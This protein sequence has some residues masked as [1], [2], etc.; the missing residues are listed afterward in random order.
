MK[1]NAREFFFFLIALV[2]TITSFL[3]LLLSRFLCSFF[4]CFSLFSYST[5]LF[6]FFMKCTIILCRR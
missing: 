6:F 5:T 3:N 2:A 1:E 4:F